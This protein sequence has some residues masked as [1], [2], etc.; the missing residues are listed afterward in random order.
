MD[1]PAHVDDVQYMRKQFINLLVLTS[2]GLLPAAITT[3]CA[4]MHHQESA[5]EYGSDAKITARIK[6]D[7]YKDPVVKGT[8]VKVS[9]M[10]GIVQLSGFVES[11]QAKDR[12]GEIARSIPGVT[13]VHNDLILPTGR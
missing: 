11:Q 1:L 12:A 7:L 8:E 9:T 5:G 3:G 13:D 10:R 2:L 4:V 6:T